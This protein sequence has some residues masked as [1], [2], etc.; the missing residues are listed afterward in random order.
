VAGLVAESGEVRRQGALACP[1][2]TR[3]HGDDVHKESPR[4][5]RECWPAMVNEWLLRN[6]YV[7]RRRY[8]VTNT[9]A[10]ET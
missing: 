7:S 1:T 4:Q 8:I 6:L 3:R 10:I 2:L 5:R 9:V